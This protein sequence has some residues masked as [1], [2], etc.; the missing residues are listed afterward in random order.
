M[1]P[2]AKRRTEGHRRWLPRISKAK[3]K[4]M[5]EEATVDCYNESERIAGWYTMIEESL[6]V[7]F[8]TMVLGVGHGP[9]RQQHAAASL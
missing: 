2:T 4:V 6:V 8:E 7:P 3:L 1:A 5:I 9:S